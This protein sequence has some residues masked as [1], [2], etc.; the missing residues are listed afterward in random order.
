MAAGGCELGQDRSEGSMGWGQSW[1][2]IWALLL[3]SWVVWGQMLRLSGPQSLVK[4]GCTGWCEF[5]FKLFFFP[6]L[7]QQVV[8]TLWSVPL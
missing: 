7:I 4:L 8:L 6:G 3:P 2:L 5:F 1:F